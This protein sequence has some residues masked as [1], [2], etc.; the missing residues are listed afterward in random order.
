MG[1]A[2]AGLRCRALFGTGCSRP[3]SILKSWLSWPPSRILC[4]RYANIRLG[5]LLWK[6]GEKDE[7]RKRLNA[8]LA[9]LEEEL[10]QGNRYP[11]VPYGIASIHAVRG[12]KAETYEWLQKAIDT[13]YR[14]V[15]LVSMDPLFE[16]LHDD[17]RF[18]EMMS[19][20]QTEVDAIR[21][22]I[23]VME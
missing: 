1:L 21:E 11:D 23:E 10:R 4:A 12:E 6:T 17:S 22:E 8:S 20:L 2:Q 18:K 16:H 5:Y 19:Q 7:A 9:L 3:R 14:E 15:R 13:G